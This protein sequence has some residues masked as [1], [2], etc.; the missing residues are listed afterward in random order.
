MPFYIGEFMGTEVIITRS[1]VGKVNANACAQTFIHKFDVD[2]IINTG[3][4]G[5]L[6][7]DVKVG[8]IV[9]STNV[10]HHDVSKTQM[11]T[12][13]R[14]KKNLLQVRNW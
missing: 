6:H 1:G 3:V 2:S 5:G 11:K 9:I 7:S 12:Y 4:A 13:F 8:D 14:S 10:T